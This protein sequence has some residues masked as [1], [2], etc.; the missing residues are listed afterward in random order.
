MEQR[1]FAVVVFQL[2]ATFEVKCIKHC[3]SNYGHNYLHSCTYYTHSRQPL[4][5]FHCFN[6]A[7]IWR[8]TVYIA[9]ALCSRSS[10]PPPLQE[11]YPSTS[12]KLASFLLRV[13]HETYILHFTFGVWTHSETRP[14]YTQWTGSITSPNLGTLHLPLNSVIYHFELGIG[15]WIGQSIFNFEA[16]HNKLQ[17]EKWVWCFCMSISNWKLTSA[18]ISLCWDQK[19][20]AVH[21]STL[22]LNLWT[23]SSGRNDLDHDIPRFSKIKEMNR[24][25]DILRCRYILY[26]LPKGVSFII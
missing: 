16:G 26:W 12:Q 20:T 8:I 9:K 7:R 25:V 14:F 13:F 22:R 21:P 11:M 3:M 24:M 2:L 17:I 19:L 23:L 10:H 6:V 4:I 15:N 5:E 18:H 1:A